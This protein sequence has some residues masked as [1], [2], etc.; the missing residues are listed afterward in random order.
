MDN[1]KGRKLC[2][3]FLFSVQGIPRAEI[4]EDEERSETVHCP[5]G[6]QFLQ[7]YVPMQ[8]GAVCKVYGIFTSNGRS[9]KM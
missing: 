3:Y 6:K 8:S 5:T 1:D 7:G 4:H 9:S 2:P